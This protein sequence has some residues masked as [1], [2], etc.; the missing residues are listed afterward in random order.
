VFEIYRDALVTE[1]VRSLQRFL[2]MT[3]TMAERNTVIGGFLERT[4]LNGQM[5]GRWVEDEESPEGRVFVPD[6][7][8]FGAGSVAWIMG[9][10]VT[11]S[12][13]SKSYAS[14]QMQY[15]DPIATTTFK[16][17]GYMAYRNI[18]EEVHQVHAL[19]AGES[20]PS[21][22]SR[23][24]AIS[25]FVADVR[26]TKSIVDEAG[27]WLIETVLAMAALFSGQPGRYDELRAN[28]ES[29]LD[30]GPTTTEAQQLVINQRG[31]G[32][33]SLETAMVRSD[34]DDPDAEL[35]KIEA[36]KAADM[37]QQFFALRGGEAPNLGGD[38]TTAP[39]GQVIATPPV[40][41][42][43]GSNS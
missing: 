23:R 1:Q 21:G 35:A 14:P 2:N 26:K 36:E 13:G 20:A 12:D 42:P 33:L 22:E 40:T 32:I 3:L 37:A 24:Q 9:A 5:P 43:V 18:L 8:R 28:F 10:E 38:F 15:R 11:Q 25:D 7:M 39:N 30:P 41:G 19:L 27:R 29:R 31:A 16:D 4:I 6:P 34:V 17:S